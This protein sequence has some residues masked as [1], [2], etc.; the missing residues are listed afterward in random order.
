MKSDQ[1]TRKSWKKLY[2]RNIEKKLTEYRI[3]SPSLEVSKILRPHSQVVWFCPPPLFSPS[4]FRTYA[5]YLAPK[6]QWSK[7]FA[8]FYLRMHLK[9]FHP[10]ATLPKIFPPVDQKTLK[11]WKMCFRNIEQNLIKSDIFRLP[12]RGVFT[13]FFAPHRYLMETYSLHKKSVSSPPP[14]PR[15]KLC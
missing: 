2:F 15:H 13:K 4:F 11:L 7:I 6:Y 9:K 1:N 10:P 5:Y 12:F 14:T 8:P 3:I